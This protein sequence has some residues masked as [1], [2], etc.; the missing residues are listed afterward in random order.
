MNRLRKKISG[1]PSDNGA[2]MV[3]TLLVMAVLTGVGAIVF[4]IGLNNM[5]NAGRDRLAGGA[6][7]ASEGGVAQALTFVRSNGVGAMKCT[8]PEVSGNCDALWGKD[9]PK[10]VALSGGKEFSVWVQK[11][12]PF[13][14]PDYKVGTYMIHST[15]TAGKGPGRRDLEVTFAVKPLTFPIGIYADNINDGG[16]AS[17]S[18]L[19]MLSKGCIGGRKAI[20]FRGIDPY[21]KIPAA[22]HSIDVIALPPNSCSALDTIHLE[23]TLPPPDEGDCNEEDQSTPQGV[24]VDEY[25]DDQDKFGGNLN[26]VEG[27]PCLG[28]AGGY[29]QTSFFDLNSP[30]PN[31]LYSYGYNENETRGLTKAEYLQLKGKA[32]EQN[33]FS[34]SARKCNV[35][36][37]PPSCWREPDAV[38]DPNAVMYWDLRGAPSNA[39]QVSLQGGDIDG[40]PNANP[41]K[42]LYGGGHKDPPGA[43]GQRSLVLVVEGG[44]MKVNSGVDIVGA[45]FVPDGSYTGNGDHNIIGILYAKVIEKF[46][47]TANFTL[48]GPSPNENCFFD[49]FPGGLLSVTTTKFHEKDR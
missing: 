41:S 13:A 31:G 4:N 9:N 22:A 21:H 47:G 5:Q 20:T 19:T 18:N 17:V 16:G 27:L 11:V 30:F 38:A 3:V 23:R 43:C 2:A 29:P 14:P 39:K 35:N 10:I 8:V 45:I 24:E 36:E 48:T 44:N 26:D 46:T 49:N 40:D 15:G 34:T 32:Q 6:L 12:N 25:A 1:V 37:S 28:T 33:Y 42:S 7:G